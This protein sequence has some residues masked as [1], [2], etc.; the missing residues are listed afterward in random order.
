MPDNEETAVNWQQVLD[1]S[2]GISVWKVRN[3]E[4]HRNL[5]LIQQERN[6][7]LMEEEDYE[8]RVPRAYV[9]RFDRR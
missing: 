9:A 7:Q 6:R 4:V 2:E 1:D 3:T 5:S 8:G